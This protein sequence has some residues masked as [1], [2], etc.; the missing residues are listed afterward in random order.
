MPLERTPEELQ[1]WAAGMAALAQAPN[2]TVK[3]S[4]L[5][6]ANPEWTVDSIRPIV[7]RTIELFGIERCFF[8]SNFPVDGLFS[9]YD[10][11][12]EAY[13][14]ILQDFSLSE[15]QQFFSENAVRLYRLSM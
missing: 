2:V 13:K 15:R 4:G 12:V 7:L 3:I 14:T 6:V 5:G 8:A 1:N 10:T 11:L 9:S